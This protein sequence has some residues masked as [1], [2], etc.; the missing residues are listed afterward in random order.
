MLSMQ[1]KS[2]NIIRT[3]N[4]KIQT[5]KLWS[6][7][8]SKFWQLWMTGGAD[9][10]EWPVAMQTAMNDRWPCWQ[11]WMTGGPGWQLWMSGGPCWQLWMYTSGHVKGEDSIGTISVAEVTVFA[12]GRGKPEHKINGIYIFHIYVCVCCVCVCVRACVC[13]YIN[14][15]HQVGIYGAVFPPS[16]QVPAIEETWRA[17]ATI[18]VSSQTHLILL[19]SN[20]YSFSWCVL[21]VQRLQYSHSTIHDLLGQVLGVQVSFCPNEPFLIQITW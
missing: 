6:E 10:Y 8:N 20:S 14:Q 3:E 16:V 4:Y 1:N 19:A 11:L 17:K 18:F 2:I 15:C 13:S 7:H 21:L 5:K 9:S 12:W